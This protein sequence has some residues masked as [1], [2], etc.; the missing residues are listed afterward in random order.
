LTLPDG[1][2]DAYK[3]LVL[4]PVRAMANLYD[5]YYA[6][7]MNKK[8]AAD[9]DLR[10]NYWADYADSCFTRDAAFAADYN[11]N[12]AGGKWDHMMDQTHIGYR[13]WDEPRGGNVKPTVVRVQ[14][15]EAVAGGYVFTEKDGVVVIEAEHYYS[16]HGIDGANWT[17]IPGLGRTL[18]GVALLPY[19]VPTDG[20]GISYRVKLAGHP[21][22]VRLRMVFNTTLPF[23][24]GGQRVSAGFDGAAIANW[25]INEDLTWANNYS[26]MYPAAGARI[27]ETTTTLTVPKRED[28]L[29]TLTI[30]PLDPGVVLFKVIVDDGGYENSFLKMRES[31]YAKD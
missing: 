29:Y 4:H 26:K 14:P 25:N 19:T 7:A 11:H 2:K 13:S 8:L 9:K 30:R 31:P 27:I 6:V 20:A 24:K 16:A 10:A 12:I 18:S 1:Y 21:D 15:S 22:S 28:G 3:E 17:V 23:K 5:L